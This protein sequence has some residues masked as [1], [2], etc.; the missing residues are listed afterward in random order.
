[1]F[2]NR[3]IHVKNGVFN[4]SKKWKNYIERNGGTVESV[5]QSLDV[6]FDSQFE[7]QNHRL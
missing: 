3:D 5:F 6:Y 1:M 7:Y 4:I 2:Y